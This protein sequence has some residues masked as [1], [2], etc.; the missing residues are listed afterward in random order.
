MGAKDVRIIPLEVGTLE[1]EQCECTLRRGIGKRVK[2]AI[3]CLVY[4]GA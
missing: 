2:C 1:W 4:R 3:Y